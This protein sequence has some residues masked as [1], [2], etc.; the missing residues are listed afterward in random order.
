MDSGA[1]GGSSPVTKSEKHADC[2]DCEDEGSGSGSGRAESV[3]SATG[4]G[5]LES[6][7]PDDRVRG[8]STK[9]PI[10]A[11]CQSNARSFDPAPRLTSSA[12]EKWELVTCGT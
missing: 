1:A 2:E 3:E 11:L 9:L 4:G 7:P 6:S 10:D 5:G 12:L 8:A